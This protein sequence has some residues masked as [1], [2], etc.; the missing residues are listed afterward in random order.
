MDINQSAKRIV[1]L[2]TK[3]HNRRAKRLI[4]EATG[5]RSPLMDLVDEGWQPDDEEENDS[6]AP[7]KSDGQGGSDGQSSAETHD[8]CCSDRASDACDEQT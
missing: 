4:D 8:P 6:P 5:D 2:T 3:E 1:D 7:E